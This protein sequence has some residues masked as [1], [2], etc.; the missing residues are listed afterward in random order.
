M[1]EHPKERTSHLDD[2]KLIREHIHRMLLKLRSHQAGDKRSGAS[3]QRDR[4]K[5]SA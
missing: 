3:V 2:R 5:D 1:P 4:E